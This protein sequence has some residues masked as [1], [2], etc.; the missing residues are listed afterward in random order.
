MDG[1]LFGEADLQSVWDG[2]GD[3][4]Q[5]Q[6][7][8]YRQVGILSSWLLVNPGLYSCRRS[9]SI[10]STSYLQQLLHIADYPWTFLSLYLSLH[11]HHHYHHH[12]HRCSHHPPQERL[13][14]KPNKHPSTVTTEILGGD[15]PTHCYTWLHGCRSHAYTSGPSVSFLFNVLLFSYTTIFHP[16]RYQLLPSGHSPSFPI[17]SVAV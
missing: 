12:C 2:S 9:L 13:Q 11:F 7:C 4:Y 6:D 14:P 17:T 16:W 15:Y 8:E 1:L 5:F 3:L 10:S